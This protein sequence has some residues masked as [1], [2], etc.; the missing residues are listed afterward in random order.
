[1]ATGSRKGRG[2]SSGS[3]EA[4]SRRRQKL[5]ALSEGTILLDRRKALRFASG[6][7]DVNLRPEEPEEEATIGRVVVYSSVHPP[8]EGIRSSSSSSSS[9]ASSDEESQTDDTSGFRPLLPVSA[10]D[11]LEGIPQLECNL[12]KFY[13]NLNYGDLC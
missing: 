11:L 2:R 13:A 1:M 4:Q 9:S 3:A 8:P 7:V 12:C 10:Q 5:K 6:Y